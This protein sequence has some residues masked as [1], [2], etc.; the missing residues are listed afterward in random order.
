MVNNPNRRVAPIAHVA[1]S[2]TP[3]CF[4]PRLSPRGRR[5]RSP[6]DSPAYTRARIVYLWVEDTQ[7]AREICGLTLARNLRSIN[8]RLARISASPRSCVTGFRVSPAQIAVLR[9][10]RATRGNENTINT[11][12]PE[13]RRRRSYCRGGILSRSL[14]QPPRLRRTREA[15]RAA[16]QAAIRRADEILCLHDTVILYRRRRSAAAPLRTLSSSFSAHSIPSAFRVVQPFANAP[17][18]RGCFAGRLPKFIPILHRRPVIQPS[19]M[20]MM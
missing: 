7:L 18:V 19:L 6:A 2:R 13:R 11:T 20:N 10:T 9:T 14:L 5:G 4:T 15:P 3:G 12:L 8:E 1:R 17:V 16:T